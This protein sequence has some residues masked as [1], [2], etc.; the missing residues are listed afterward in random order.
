MDR[1]ITRRDFM[2]GVGVAIGGAVL[3]ARADDGSA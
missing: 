3:G 2:N 1:E